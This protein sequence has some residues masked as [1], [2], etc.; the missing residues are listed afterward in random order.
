MIEVVSAVGTMWEGLELDERPAQGNSSV[1]Y[2]TLRQMLSLP[3]YGIPWVSPDVR[4]SAGGGATR[5]NDEAAPPAVAAGQA[6]LEFTY[7]R[8]HARAPALGKAIPSLRSTSGGS[9]E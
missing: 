4:G 2:L 6:S 9:S 7:T 8:V 3:I 5:R 1:P